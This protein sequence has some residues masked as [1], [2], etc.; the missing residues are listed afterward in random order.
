MQP[1]DHK[2]LA[3][4]THRFSIPCVGL[5]MLNRPFLGQVVLI[6]ATSVLTGA[7]PEGNFKTVDERYLKAI[8]DAEEK[9]FANLNKVLA[10]AKDK[11]AR[12]KIAYEIEQFKKYKL[13]PAGVPTKD[14]VRARD[15]AITALASQYEP[16]IKAQRAAKNSDEADTLEK[17]YGTL[18][19]NARGFGIAIPDPASRP[20]VIIRNVAE[21]AVLEAIDPKRSGSRLTVAK[22]ARGKPGQIWRLEQGEGG[23]AFRSTLSNLCLHVPA[24]TRTEGDRLILYG[25]E[26]LNA[27]YSWTADEQLREVVFVSCFNDLVLSVKEITEKG[28]VGTFIIQEKRSEEKPARQYWKIELAK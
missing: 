7:Q 6:V 23:V 14:Y 20:F 15:A 16:A 1:C 18:V 17:N 25:P 10:K 12:E 9:L 2:S 13:I 8:S 28:Q 3:R 5:P 24:G 27:H 26:S 11:P 19:K 21:N 4:G 22:Y